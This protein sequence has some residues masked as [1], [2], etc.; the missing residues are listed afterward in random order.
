[1][2]NQKIN[3]KIVNDQKINNQIQTKKLEVHSNTDLS[4]KNTLMLE[5]KLAAHQKVGS[6]K[7]YIKKWLEHN[8]TEKLVVFAHHRVMLNGIELTLQETTNNS[9]NLPFSYIRIDGSTPQHR[10]QGMVYSFQT[11]PI[12]RV[13][14]LS[15]TSASTGITLHSSNTVIFTELW[16]NPGNILQAEDRVHRIGQKNMVSIIFLLGRNTIDEH[17]WPKLIQ[18]LKVLEKMDVGENV[19]GDVGAREGGVLPFKR[20][21]TS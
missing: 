5:Y 19:F 2:N 3:N 13:A 11:D 18:K 21:R 9:D 16:W 12:V 7:N 10:R 17:V 4:D 6:V 15:I 20:S 1:I 8:P 14:L